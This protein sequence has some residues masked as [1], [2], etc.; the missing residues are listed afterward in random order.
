VVRVGWRG[1]NDDSKEKLLLVDFKTLSP[2]EM[3]AAREDARA[4]E[5]RAY[6]ISKDVFGTTP[7]ARVIRH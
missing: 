2:S 7:R 5:D 1:E 4:L 6:R 3:D